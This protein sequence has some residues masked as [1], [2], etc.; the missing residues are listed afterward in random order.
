MMR[1]LAIASLL[2]AGV[3]LSAGALAQAAMPQSTT[4]AQPAP[5]SMRTSN[6]AMAPMTDATHAAKPMHKTAQHK[7]HHNKTHHKMHKAAHRT[8]VPAMDVPAAATS[9]G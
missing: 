6:A 7:A 2:V 5:A 9:A 3:A 4:E 8:A 1:Q